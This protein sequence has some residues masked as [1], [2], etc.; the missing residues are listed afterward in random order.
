MSRF[1]DVLRRAKDQLDVPEPV[2]SRILLEMASDLE[3]SYQHFRARGI[4]ED[5]ACRL[6]EETFGTSPEALGR[7]A[8]VHAAGAS[9]VQHRFFQQL[10]TWWARI[11]L[12]LLLGS[13]VVL[14][15]KVLTTRTFWVFVSPFVWPIGILAAATFAFTTWK[16][17]Q[18]FSFKGDDTGQLREGLGVPLVFAAASLV[19]AMGGLLFHLQRFFRINADGAPESLFMNFA[20]WMATIS[21]MMVAGLLTAILAGFLWFILT[22]LVARIEV[23]RVES[24]V[25]STAAQ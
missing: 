8:R 9:G 24:L 21:S 12:V 14:A 10:T 16:L 22:R 3:D 4:D 1:A 17:W 2:R 20:G 13:E 15:V 25:G 18:I 23:R 7:L 6:A 11:L 19:V 5:E